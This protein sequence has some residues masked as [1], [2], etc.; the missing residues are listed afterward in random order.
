MLGMK[1]GFT[2][3]VLSLFSC[4]YIAQAAAFSCGAG[5]VY[6]KS[7]KDIDG[8]ETYECQKL[9]CYDLETGK[10]MGNGDKENSGYRQTSAPVELTDI[11]GNTIECWGERVWCAG[12]TRGEWNPQYGMYTRGG[13]DSVTYHSYKKGSCF[14]WRLSKPSCGAGESA[15]LKDEEWVCVTQGETVE[16]KRTSTIRR[17]G[18]IR[19]MR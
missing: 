16:Q 4:A 1:K 17:T 11:D 19:R 5:Y 12:E 7:R 15:I 6:E 10:V 14:A 18:A 2:T 8:I 3:L 9:W 13:M